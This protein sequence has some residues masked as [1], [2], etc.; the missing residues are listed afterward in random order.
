[1][2]ALHPDQ[3]SKL[4][5]DPATANAL[6]QGE[7]VSAGLWNKC[8]RH[9]NDLSCTSPSISYVFDPV[10]IWTA[11]ADS[12]QEF[13]PPQL[14]QTLRGHTVSTIYI[15][16]FF[17]V[18]MGL[19]LLGAIAGIIT[20]CVGRRS[21]RVLARIAMTFYI[22]TTIVDLVGAALTTKAYL[23]L[24][25]AL[26]TAFGDVIRNTHSKRTNAVLWLTVV[27]GLF[28]SMFSVLAWRKEIK[29]QRIRGGVLEVGAGHKWQTDAFDMATDHH[30]AAAPRPSREMREHDEHPLLEK[31]TAYEPQV[32]PLP[33]SA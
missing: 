14:V 15:K 22:V 19:S 9:G 21:R 1:M 27:F 33:H 20:T 3:I 29:Y 24:M 18:G 13:L 17:I 32:V 16:I 10:T 2:T 11:D 5:V 28:A 26:G 7:Y 8:V 30:A 23:D 6:A 31:S 4:H 12:A 25:R